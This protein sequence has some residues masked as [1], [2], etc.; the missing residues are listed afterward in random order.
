MPKTRKRKEDEVRTLKDKLARSKSVVF[1]NQTGITVSQSETLRKKLRAA[2]GEFQATKKTLLKLALKDVAD[3][4]TS[5][6][7]GGVALAFSYED[8][9]AA[10]KQV[11]EFSKEF[12][13]MQIVGGVLD[14]A[15]ISSEAVMALAKLPGKQELLGLLVRTIQA[16]VSG[17]VNA[18]AGNIRNFVYVVQAIKDSKSN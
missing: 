17:F 4:D 3:V 9:V 12:T 1:V 15:P 16:P 14:Q 2:S 11:F 7:F 6:F 5:V 18:L 13:G 8:E 10:A